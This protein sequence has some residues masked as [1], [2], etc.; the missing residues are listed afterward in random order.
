MD[1]KSVFRRVGG[2]I[3]ITVLVPV[4]YTHL[5]KEKTGFREAVRGQTTEK[6]TKFQKMGFSVSTVYT[7]ME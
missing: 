1:Q 6:A 3:V 5:F 2:L 7:I 4:S